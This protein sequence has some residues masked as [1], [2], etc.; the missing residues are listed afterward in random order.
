MKKIEK[1]A[2]PKN[3]TLRLLEKVKTVHYERQANVVEN[4]KN[5]VKALRFLFINP[6]KIRV[7][8]A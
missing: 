2:W 5:Y 1:A 3:K 6:Q 4:S 8:K 7:V